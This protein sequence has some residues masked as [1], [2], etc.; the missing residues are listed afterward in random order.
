MCWVLGSGFWCLGFWVL[1]WAWALAWA[2]AWVCVS[3]SK[4]KMTDVEQR[5]QHEQNTV[6]RC[7]TRAQA[8][9]QVAVAPSQLIYMKM[10]THGWEHNKPNWQSPE[11]HITRLEVC[12]NP[13]SL[14]HMSR[15]PLTSQKTKT[16]EIFEY[17]WSKM[18]LDRIKTSCGC[19]CHGNWF[20]QSR[21]LCQMWHVLLTNL[22][23]VMVVS[24]AI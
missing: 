1:V 12:S 15:C 13:L 7:A 10:H 18:I 19:S 9:E 4:K 24:V 8:S 14:V 2:W 23:S 22:C 21:R 3:V 16:S 6:G 11:L 17:Q 5:Q 20:T